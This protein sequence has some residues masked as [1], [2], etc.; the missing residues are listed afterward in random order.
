MFDLTR[1]TAPPLASSSSGPESTEDFS[2]RLSLAPSEATAEAEANLARIASVEEGLR[3]LI[4][5]GVKANRLACAL[6]LLG[7]IPHVE[8]AYRLAR[9]CGARQ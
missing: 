7:V 3:I 5:D 4:E 9:R 6:S 1:G 2:A 8:D